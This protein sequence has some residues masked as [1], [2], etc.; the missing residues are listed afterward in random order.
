MQP[1]LE[2]ATGIEEV[3]SKRFATLTT[4]CQNIQP[5]V[6]RSAVIFPLQISAENQKCNY[7]AGILVSF[8][9]NLPQQPTVRTFDNS[10]KN[11]ST[12]RGNVSAYRRF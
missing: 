9:L 2:R 5:V 7:S 12:H 6:E 10:K 11:D 8:D 3:C 4:V 1:L